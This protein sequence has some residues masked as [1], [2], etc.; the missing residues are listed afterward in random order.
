LFFLWVLLHF[1]MGG[2][3]NAQLLLTQFGLLPWL[4]LAGVAG[5][6][7]Y[8]SD[9]RTD[10]PLFAAGLLLVPPALLARSLPILF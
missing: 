1:G 8:R 7:L 2:F 9:Y 6:L 3:E 5:L 10:L 4:I